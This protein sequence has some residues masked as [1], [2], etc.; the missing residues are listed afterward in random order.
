[1]A[2][3]RAWSITTS[4]GGANPG[5][6]RSRPSSGQADFALDAALC[7]RALVTGQDPVTGAALTATSRPRWRRARQ[8]APAW[9]RS[10]LNGNLRGKPTLIVAGRSDALVPV[11]NNVARLR[12]LQPGGRGQREPA[13]LHRGHQRPAL[14]HLHAATRLRHS[15]RAATRATSTRRW[16]RCTRS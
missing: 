14:R 9:P 11:N 2:C 12:R 5:P 8:C 10:L 6:S 13:A 16:T 7:Q 4:I 3:R 1:M 15:L